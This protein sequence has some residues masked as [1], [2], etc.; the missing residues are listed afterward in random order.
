MIAWV[1]SFKSA[2]IAKMQWREI[3]RYV[4]KRINSAGGIFM[5]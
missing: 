3:K 4:G 2:G 5:G 1:Q